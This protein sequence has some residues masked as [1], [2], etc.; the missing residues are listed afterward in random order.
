MSISYESL[1]YG[2]K[3]NQLLQKKLKLSINGKIVRQGHLVLYSF[4]NYCIEM[5]FKNK[6]ESK[7][8]KTEIPIPFDITL[9]K[10]GMIFDYR[11]ISLY[12]DTDVVSEFKESIQHTEN[13][14]FNNKLKVEILKSE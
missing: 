2:D 13:K 3:L 12:N 1:D 6:T 5:Y 14:F 11:L 10:Q 7:L 4:K 8:R 9:T